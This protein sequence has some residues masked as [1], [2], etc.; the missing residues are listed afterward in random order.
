MMDLIDLYKT[1]EKEKYSIM[2]V[3]N[4]VSLIKRPKNLIMVI[5]KK[6]L[7]MSKD[8]SMLKALNLLKFQ[9]PLL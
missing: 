2:T 5:G 6:L 8:I 7:K 4:H 1:S 9:A 3:K